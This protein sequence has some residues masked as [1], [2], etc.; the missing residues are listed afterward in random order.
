M[1]DITSSAYIGTAI[2][3]DYLDMFVVS[4]SLS[5]SVVREI[6]SLIS[7]IL[8][9]GAC[10]S[11][12]FLGIQF[13]DRIFAPINN[14]AQGMKRIDVDSIKILHKEILKLQVGSNTADSDNFEPLLAYHNLLG[15]VS[16]AN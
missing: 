14:L 7:T 1:Y 15:I 11:V 2:N 12:I 6:T 8:I 5:I 13:S 4:K 10:L 9:C 16:E 3:L